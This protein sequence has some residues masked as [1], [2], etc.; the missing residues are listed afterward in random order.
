MMT[1]NDEKTR[2]WTEN[3]FVVDL[4][5]H[6]DEGEAQDH[7]RIILPL[8]SYLALDEAFRA[9]SA[10][11]LGV[12]LKPEESVAELGPF[13]A[14]VPLVAL[15]FPAFNDGRSF[16]KAELLRRL[17]FEGRIRA[18]GDVLI[19]QIPL[20][21]RC[22]FQEFEVSNETALKRLSQGRSGG[23]PLHYQPAA[24]ESRAGQTFSWRRRPAA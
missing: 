1:E 15:P 12:T 4:W 22:G 23:I 19:D 10:A 17:G 6:Q 8:A 24:L 2:L 3:G 5:R 7:G 18:T 16:S 11:R 20:M 21:L 9:A 14:H 13:L